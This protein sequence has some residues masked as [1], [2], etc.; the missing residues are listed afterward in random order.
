MD[1]QQIRRAAALAVHS[2]LGDRLRLGGAGVGSLGVLMD[3]ARDVFAAAGYPRALTFTDYY[4]AYRRQDVARTIVTAKP[5]ETWRLSPVV[6]DGPTVEDGK[7]GTPFAKALQ[8]LADGAEI[9]DSLVGAPGLW[10]ALH[11]LDRVSRI[12]RYAILYIG[13]RGADKPSEPLTKGA[14]GGVDDLLYLA[15]YDEA[16]AEIASFVK[17]PADPRFGLP[18]FYNLTT[19]TGA[20]DSSRAERVHWSRCIHVAEGL[21]SDEIYGTPALEAAWNRLVDLLKILAGSGE[22]AWKLLDPG[23]TITANEGKRLPTTEAEIGA[24]EEQIEDFINGYTRWLMLEGMTPTPLPGS[25]Q[26]PTGLVMMNLTLIAA[27]TEIPKRIF[28]GTEE[29]QLAGA[30]DERRWA[31][32]IQT[33]QVNHV[34]PQIILPLVNRLVY[35]GVL[36]KPSTGKAAVRWENLLE[37]NREAEANT[38]KTAAEALNAVKA[39]VDPKVF[40]ETYLPE[41]PSD[42]IEEEPPPPPPQQFGL[43]PAPGQPGEAQGQPGDPTDTQ[44][45]QEATGPQG[46]QQEEPAANVALAL[47]VD[48]DGN[49]FYAYP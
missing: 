31:T 5:S 46:G 48:S 7:D 9:G 42:A 20:G 2:V 8:T 41:L 40:V 18:E 25:V 49:W 30:Q 39:K 37:S 14:A 29:A 6:L 10:Q 28:L 38:A 21:D 27:A 47:G 45:G 44:D 26:D 34:E 33:R 19:T 32:V 17:D 1:E 11:R 3:G 13:L 12:G 43:P 4:E 23:Y 22:A 16:K 36:P 15:V 24:I 35:A